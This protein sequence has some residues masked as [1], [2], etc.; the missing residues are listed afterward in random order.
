MTKIVSSR[1]RGFTLIELLVVIAIIAVLIA[2]LLP[3]VQQAREAARRSQC[4]NNLKQLG[5]AMHNYH[6]VTNKFP[7]GNLYA[8]AGASHPRQGG[9]YGNWA[10]TSPGASWGWA[11]HIL[12]YVEAA[13]VY[14]KVD[15][16]SPPYTSNWAEGGVNKGADT[17]STVNQAVCQSQPPA[18]VCPS[19]ARLG[20]EKE[21]KDYAINAGT[22]AACCPERDMGTTHLGIANRNTSY[23]FRDITD[24]TTNTLML[25]EQSHRFTGSTIYSNPFMWVI[26]TTDGYFSSFYTPNKQY[27]SD[28]GRWCGSPH[29][30][31]VHAAM[32]DGSVKF[33][34]DNIDANLWKALSTRASGEVVSL[35]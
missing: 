28:I 25:A 29:V 13:N 35:E 17:T 9:A 5:L 6:E 22:F 33:F 18:F 19:V 32:C 30:G 14:N 31:G 26:H 10:S 2:L 24:G 23:S 21:F 27:G 34:S 3:A 15:V 4:K 12:P 16:N 11:L 1:Q 7:P 8:G 20:S